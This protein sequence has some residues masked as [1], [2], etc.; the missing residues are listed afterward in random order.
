VKVLV[1]HNRYRAER[2]S[3]ENVLVEAEARLLEEHGCRVE[4]LVVSS[5]DIG[6]WPAARKALLPAR[7]V[8][9]LAGY[10]LMA[11]AIERFRP[12]V[13]HV[14][15]TFPLLSPSVLWAAR[16]SGAAVVLTLHNFRPLCPA[17]NFLRDGQICEEC[18]GRVPI[19]AVRHGCYR[20]SRAATVPLAVMSAVHELA[21]TWIRCVDTLIVP[22]EFARR[23]YVRAGWPPSKLAVKYNGVPEPGSRREGPGNGFTC[24]ARLDVE[25]GVDVLLRAWAEAFPH[26]EES[27]LVLGSGTREAVLRRVARAQRG[28]EFHG[29]VERSRALELVAAARS[30]ILPSRYYETF[31][32]ALV[33]AYSLGVPV[34][35]SRIGALSEIVEDGRTG[36]LVP[37]DSPVELASALVRMANSAE[38]SLRLGR[39]ARSTYERRFHPDRT[40]ERL[41]TIYGRA[42]QGDAAA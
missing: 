36:L 14:H 5:D 26:G 41:I 28:V 2:P 17:A 25:K 10:R 39:E 24:L 4:R 27:L 35:A 40:T 31:G 20:D 29:H 22:S 9:S 18:L 1:V 37:P 33:E 42:L 34:I 23:T 13:V 15:N 8:W 6:L 3:G 11:D 38:L 7:V 19:P 16:S 21:G 30:L 32:L 12:D